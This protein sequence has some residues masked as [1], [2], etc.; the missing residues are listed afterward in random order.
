MTNRLLVGHRSRT[1]PTGYGGNDSYTKVLLDFESGVA[2]SNVGGLAKTW[3]AHGAIATTGSQ[4]VFGSKSLACTGN[5]NDYIDTPDS[6]D[7]NLGAAASWE[8]DFWFKVGGGDGTRRYI[9]GQCD[10]GGNDF[11]IACA[12]NENNKLWV[13]LSNTGNTIPATLITGTTFLTSGATWHHA[14]IQFNGYYYLL[15]VDGVIQNT[16]NGVFSSALWNSSSPF[17]IGRPGAGAF[18]AFNGWV[19]EFRISVGEQRF[20]TFAYTVPTQPYDQLGT[21]TFTDYGVWLSKPG[22]DVF[23]ATDDQC[24]LTTGAKNFQFLMRGSVA[25]PASTNVTVY[26]GTTLASIPVIGWGVKK[27]V[28]GWINL[29]A[30]DSN[31][32]N[33]GEA[34]GIVMKVQPFTDR[35]VFKNIYTIDETVVY[36]VLG[37]S[38]A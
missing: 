4:F 8:I 6:A 33:D 23:T 37:M 18:N 22:I 36:V 24:L 17:A 14:V 16:T 7:F 21:S 15:F 34:L 35:I 26:F 3:T 31:L 27:T 1:V 2:D 29:P 25:V 28:G 38:A 10:S 11:S 30:F 12:V 5:V 32:P 20:Y 19:D 9:F 13:Q